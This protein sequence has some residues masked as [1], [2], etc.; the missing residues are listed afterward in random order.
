MKQNI[1]NFMTMTL[2]TVL[3]SCGI[4][5]FK[6]P[7]HF[8]IGGI[9]GISVILGALFKNIPTENFI[10]MIN[11]LLLLAGFLIIGKGFGAKPVYCSMLMSVLVVL[12]KKLVPLQAPLTTQPLLELVFAIFLQ[13]AGSALLFNCDASTGGT[14]IIA[15]II[16]KYFHTNI[17]K[18]LFIAD[19]F[20][21]M[22][23]AFVFG[24][25]TWLYSMLGFVARV[26]LVNNLLTDINMS[27]YCT[28]I[29]QPQYEKKISTY[30]TKTLNKSATIS[31]AYTGAYNNDKKSVLLVALSPRQARSLKDYVK[32]VDEKSFIIV[33]NTGEI[34]GKGFHEAI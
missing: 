3:I 4:Y 34:S 12:L 19:F 2:A 25:E 13:A 6:I 7:N 28:V 8:S 15:M 33:N 27:K 1:K 5:F 9:S 16:K 18:A 11:M 26:F 10:F 31:N 30:I 22:A 32:S 20:I 14:D 29:T 21:V 23:T 17:A 24:I